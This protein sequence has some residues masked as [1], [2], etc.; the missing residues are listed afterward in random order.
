M[1]SSRPIR[2]MDSGGSGD[3]G[4]H[5]RDVDGAL[6]RHVPVCCAVDGDHRQEDGC[7]EG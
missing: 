5:V 7:L 1:A 3:G 4:V 6:H 2:S